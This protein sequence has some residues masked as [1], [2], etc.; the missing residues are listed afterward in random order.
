MSDSPTIERLRLEAPKRVDELSQGPSE[1]QVVLVVEG[2]LACRP[3]KDISV[4]TGLDGDMV[5]DVVAEFGT[6]LTHSKKGS[7]RAGLVCAADMRQQTLF[8]LEFSG[9]VPLEGKGKKA[10]ESR[11]VVPLG[12]EPRAG[13]KRDVSKALAAIVV[14]APERK[15][16]ERFVARQ[17]GVRSASLNYPLVSGV[18]F[19]ASCGRLEQ[20]DKVSKDPVFHV[21]AVAAFD[22]LEVARKDAIDAIDLLVKA[23]LGADV[24]LKELGRACVKSRWI[25]EREVERVRRLVEAASQRPSVRGTLATELRFLASRVQASERV[26]GKA[27]PYRPASIAELG[28]GQVQRI[29]Q[30]SNLSVEGATR[31]EESEIRTRLKA[32]GLSNDLDRLVPEGLRAASSGHADA[33]WEIMTARSEGDN[34]WVEAFK[35]LQA[36]VSA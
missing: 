33:F 22:L 25:A 11:V 1:D 31:A 29:A 21:Q 20:I 23:G 19:M 2:L 16:I 8:Q 27:N 15:T 28:V 12:F 14:A 26:E 13:H 35:S 32:L 34:S 3:L 24:D 7:V 6:W 30:A 9:G 18:W 5:L 36:E 10:K 17:Y 4:S